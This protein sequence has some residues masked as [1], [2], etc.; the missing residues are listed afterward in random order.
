[1]KASMSPG[2]LGTLVGDVGDAHAPQVLLEQV[3]VLAIE[4]G[5]VVA[6]EPVRDA[7]SSEDLGEGLEVVVCAGA[8]DDNHLGV[9]GEAVD[10]N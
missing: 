4:G 2:V 9:P 5:V 3:A 7:V 10:D 6:V 8:L 1:M